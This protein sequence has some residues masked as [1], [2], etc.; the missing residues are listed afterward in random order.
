MKQVDFTFCLEKV[1]SEPEDISKLGD[2]MK[3]EITI[4]KID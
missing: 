2:E 1:V 4:K 3:Y